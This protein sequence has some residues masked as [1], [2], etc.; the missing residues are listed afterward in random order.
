LRY[1][2]IDRVTYLERDR[3]LKAIKNVSLSED[4]FSD[5]FFGNPVFPG[6]LQIESLAQAG[7]ILLEVS[8]GFRSK[9][10]LAMVENAKFR[11]LVRPGDCLTIEARVISRDTN[12]VQ[13]DGKISIDEKLA[14]NG[15]LTFGLQPIDEFYRP[16]VRN[17][18]RLM[19]ESFLRDAELVGV[20][21]PGDDYWA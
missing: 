20:E 9:A 21:F 18:T 1:F 4:V 13:I 6:A 17:M 8:A 12:I 10:I 16:E 5:H 14:A 19:Y 7:T 11:R 15:R 2:L 3:L